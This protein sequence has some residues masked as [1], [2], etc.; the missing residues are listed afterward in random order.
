MENLVSILE[1]F[2]SNNLAVFVSSL[3]FILSLYIAYHSYFK[4]PKIEMLV[5]NKL[6]FYPLPEVVDGKVIWGGLG[7]YLPITFHNWSPRGAA[8]QEVRIVIEP[9]NDPENCYDMCWYTFNGLHETEHRWTTKGYAQPI[10]INGKS[11]AHEC[12]LFAWRADTKQ[13]IS[14]QQGEY[15]VHILGST[16]DDKT[17]S[18]KHSTSFYLTEQMLQVH[19]RYKKKQI[20]LTVDVPLGKNTRLNTITSK[21]DIKNTYGI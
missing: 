1:Y 20:P 8:I 19:E 9:M 14:L 18:L 17:P 6:A 11:S 12:I 3:A 7:F 2:N 16:P 21:N 4:P 13:K 5:S 10:A 15:I